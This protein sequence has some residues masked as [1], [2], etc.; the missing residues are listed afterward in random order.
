MARLVN[1]SCDPNM[2]A[3]RRRWRN[4][5]YPCYHAIKDIPKKVELTVSYGF[6]II[7]GKDVDGYAFKECLCNS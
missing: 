7:N 3:V 2:E 5:F 6:T 1:H 4:I